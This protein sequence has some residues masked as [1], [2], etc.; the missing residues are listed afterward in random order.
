MISSQPA[1]LLSQSYDPPAPY[2][3]K[4]R[5]LS[6][7]FS[8]LFNHCTLIRLFKM[9]DEYT[10]TITQC[11]SS[12]FCRSTATVIVA[13][14]AP[15]DLKVLFE[16]LSR[17]PPPP[18][19]WIGSEAW[20]AN[21][22]MLQFSFCAGAIGF[23]IQRSVIPGLIEFLQDFSPFKVAASPVLTEF[24]EGLFNCKLG[25]CEKIIFIAGKLLLHMN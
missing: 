23:G 1:L 16:E 8:Y 24:Y 15:G 5:V 17:N 7:K 13:F 21:Q 22:V 12:T 18:R 9:G 11:V 19:Q 10:Y 4:R 14:A 25:K 2:L 20:V 6:L 3:L